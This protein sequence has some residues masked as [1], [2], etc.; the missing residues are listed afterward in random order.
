[1]VNLAAVA[2]F[3][4]LAAGPA[5]A[6]EPRGG[7]HPGGCGGGCGGHRPPA[8]GGGFNSNINV[9]INANANANAFAGAA[10]GGYFNARAY[11][12]GGIRA[13]GY[14]GGTV[15]VGGGYGGDVGGYYGGGA[16]YNEE[17]YEGRACASAPFG[18]VVGGFGR[19]GRR[20]PACVGEGREICRGDDRGGRYGYS[21]RRGCDA[22]RREDHHASHGGSGASYESHESYEA[23]ESW[24]GGYRADHGRDERRGR[25]C[26]CRTDGGHPVPEQPVY[27]PE[28]SAWTEPPAWRDAPPPPRHAYR[29]EPGER[30]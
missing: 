20:P 27:R 30:G 3:A 1:M 7:G 22:G 11:D 5:M 13:G 21:E 17:I 25:D 16:I 9:N 28:P 29:Q 2:A 12:V 18:Y 26:D 19:E 23:Y 10:G 14:G 8:H 24:S 15:Y 6:G 4:I